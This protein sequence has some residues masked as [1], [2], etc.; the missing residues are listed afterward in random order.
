M[1]DRGAR[2]RSLAFVEECRLENC[3]R[4]RER[5]MEAQGEYEEVSKRRQ[6]AQAELVFLEAVVARIQER[7][8]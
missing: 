3:V 2:E 6:R 7:K 4:A 8:R 1:A 5:V